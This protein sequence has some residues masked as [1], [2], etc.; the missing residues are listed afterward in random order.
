MS[1]NHQGSDNH[2]ETLAECDRLQQENRVL[3]QELGPLLALQSLIGQLAE[4]APFT[5]LV[6]AA[7]RAAISVLAGKTAAVALVEPDGTLT[8]VMAEG[9]EAAA[10]RQQPLPAGR[11]VLAWVIEHRRA[12]VASGEDERVSPFER[13]FCADGAIA[14]TPLVIGGD[15]IGVLAVF[16]AEQAGDAQRAWLESAGSIVAAATQTTRLRIDLQNER[17][18]ELSSQEELRRRIARDLHDG[19]A[20]RLAALTMGL[21]IIARLSPQEPA[22]ATEEFAAAIALARRTAQELRT[23]LFELRPLVLEAQ[24]LV[25]ALQFYLDQLKPGDLVFHLAADES[26]GRMAPDVEAALLAVAREAIANVRKHAQARNCRIALTRRGKQVSLTVRDDGRGFD[27]EAVQHAYAR[28]ARFG[29]VSMQERIELVGGT[30]AIRSRPGRGTTI[31]ARIPQ[32]APVTPPP[33]TT[34]VG[35]K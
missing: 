30:F 15:R 34:Y 22:R 19:P 28:L 5:T 8:V 21:E 24:G 25:P 33:A 2:R 7:L 35:G 16:G 17:Q 31:I 26:V 23:L 1:R 29:L 27:V 9:E 3:Y 18:R 12:L 14:A 6:P 10:L 32:A 11:G 4:P 20:Q 13:T